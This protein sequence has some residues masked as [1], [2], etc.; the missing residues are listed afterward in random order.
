MP[1]EPLEPVCCKKWQKSP[2][3]ETGLGNRGPL[4]EGVTHAHFR[5]ILVVTFFAVSYSKTALESER[6][7]YLSENVIIWMKNKDFLDQK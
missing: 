6:A 2:N 7:C 4:D 5:P 1:F 3:Q